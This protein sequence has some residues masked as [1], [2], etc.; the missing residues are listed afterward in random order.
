[1]VSPIGG[2]SGRF[3]TLGINP[4]LCF[5]KN[6]YQ[7]IP[8]FPQANPQET[9]HEDSSPLPRC[10][11]RAV[12][13]HASECRDLA[14]SRS[15][16]GKYNQQADVDA[17]CQDEGL[18]RAISS[19][20]SA[21]VTIQDLHE[22]LPQERAVDGNFDLD[23]FGNSRFD[24]DRGQICS[25]ACGCVFVCCSGFVGFHCFTGQYHSDRSSG[26]CR[27]GAFDRDPSSFRDEAV[28][29]FAY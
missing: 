11:N 7:S 10:L 27:N 5:I 8:T 17:K 21:E 15:C 6:K 14:D 3:V 28:R 20:E 2:H 4:A 25:L 13:F 16:C 29:T 12:L 26:P 19:A 22:Q 23:A 24:Y 18:R 1:M 9:S